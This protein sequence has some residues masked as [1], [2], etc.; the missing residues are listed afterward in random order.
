[1]LLTPP[2]NL[3]TGHLSPS[4]LG[5]YLKCPIRWRKRYIEHAIEPLSPGALLGRAVGAAE[6]DSW[7]NQIQ[8]GSRLSTRDVLDA[9][10]DAWELAKD[11]EGDQVIWDEPS[12][13]VKDSGARVL[14]VYHELV[15]PTIVPI[16]VERAFEIHVPGVEWTIKGYMD[17]ETADEIPDLKMRSR[18]KGPVSAAEAD[19]D[20]QAGTYLA[21][22]RAEGNPADRF[23]FHSLLRAARGIPVKPGDVLVTP[24]TRTAEQ[25]DTLIDLYVRVAAEIDWRLEY[26]VWTPPPTGSW[27]CSPGW[28]G[29]W[30]ECEFGGL[31]ANGGGGGPRPA[32]HLPDSRVRAAIVATTRRDGTTT[33]ARVGSHLGLSARAAAARMAKMAGV[34][35]TR[36]TKS[37]GRGAAKTVKVIGGP[38]VYSINQGK[39]EGEVTVT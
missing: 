23:A 17:V 30:S 24:T 11:Q 14:P 38:R 10:S 13:R 22:R 8:T 3:P 31:H 2:R 39:E 36:P 19:I 12:G 5:L 9:F 16:A 20:V 15:A 34:T 35:S 37:S 26:D 1:V 32:R 7:G 4:S 18:S 28:C 21:A 27:W 29:F 6:R 33:A 25:L